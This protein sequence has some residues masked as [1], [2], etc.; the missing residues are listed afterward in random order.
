[1]NKFHTT[2]GHAYTSLIQNGMLIE[3][4]LL[5]R[6]HVLNSVELQVV[7]YNGELSFL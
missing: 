4:G 3:V 5:N 1:M 6:K 7:S 2:W